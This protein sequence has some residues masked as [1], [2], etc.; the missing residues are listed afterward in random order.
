MRQNIMRES[1]R[2][3]ACKCAAVNA[4]FG[5][6]SMYIKSCKSRNSCNLCGVILI[7][8]IQQELLEFGRLD[9]L[10]PY[11]VLRLRLTCRTCTAAVL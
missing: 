4:Q 9:L 3:R 8:T 5:Y 7:S 11:S 1:R 6:Y 2:V 10:N